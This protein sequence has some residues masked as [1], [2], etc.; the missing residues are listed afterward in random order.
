MEPESLQRTGSHTGLLDSVVPPPP[1]KPR[2]P[3]RRLTPEERA[4]M[5]EKRKKTIPEVLGPLVETADGRKMYENYEVV[6]ENENYVCVTC[7]FIT[8]PQYT[9]NWRR[10]RVIKMHIKAKHLNAYRCDSC[11]R[12]FT[13]HKCYQGHLRNVHHPEKLTLYLCDLCGKSVSDMDTHL[14]GHKSPEEKEEIIKSGKGFAILPCPKCGKEF[15]G[16]DKLAAHQI[17]AYRCKGSELYSPELIFGISSNRK[18]PCPTCGKMVFLVNLVRHEWTHKNAAEKEE[19]AR[20][21]TAPMVRCSIC[22][23]FVYRTD[24]TKHVEAHKKLGDKTH[25]HCD[26]EGCGRKYL[27]E[28]HLIRHRKMEHEGVELALSKRDLR[29]GVVSLRCPDPSCSSRRFTTQLSLQG[30]IGRRHEFKVRAERP[31][32]CEICQ[33]R[34]LIKGDL[35]RHLKNHRPREDFTL[36]CPQCPMLFF[37]SSLLKTHLTLEHAVPKESRTERDRKIREEAKNLG[38]RPFECDICHAKFQVKTALGTHM[39]KHRPREEYTLSCPHCPALFAFKQPLRWHLT[40]EHAVPKESNKV[41][42]R[43][44]YDLRKAAE[45]AKKAVKKND[46]KVPRKKNSRQSSPSRK[47]AISRPKRTKI[48]H[49]P[50]EEIEI[51]KEACPI[52]D[53]LSSE[54]EEDDDTPNDEAKVEIKSED[55]ESNGDHDNDTNWS[56]FSGEIK[57]EDESNSD[58]DGEGEYK[59]FKMLT[60][61]GNSSSDEDHG[62][63]E[64]PLKF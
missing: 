15:A 51:K 43:R 39:S 8:G 9:N 55:E 1:P 53:V 30:H 47:K 22:D 33:A 46:D 59:G 16:F 18:L 32:K 31:F 12:N 11:E 42:L 26:W 50:D 63:D 61:D 6:L 40:V 2:K 35:T 49:N 62:G 7:G 54:G 4:V 58:I 14:W 24:Y 60:F 41:R 52:R 19:T 10:L 57:S 17:Q 56:P 27:E 36:T 5:L 38:E 45:A 28:E 34:F 25:F 64:D 23:K 48:E 29:I 20:L 3:P 37:K 21:G 44:Y 13:T